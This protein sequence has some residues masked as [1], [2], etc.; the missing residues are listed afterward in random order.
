MK[1]CVIIDENCE[2][3]PMRFDRRDPFVIEDG[4]FSSRNA[5]SDIVRILRDHG[6]ACK[7]VLVEET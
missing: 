2:P 1:S 6:V 5:S 4:G 7:A 3:I